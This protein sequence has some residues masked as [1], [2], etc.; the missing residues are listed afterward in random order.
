MTLGELMDL[1]EEVL[2]ER[3]EAALFPI[4]VRGLYLTDIILEQDLDEVEFVTHHEHE[5]DEL[6]DLD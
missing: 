6:T 4:R 5:L 2:D 1:C 3:P